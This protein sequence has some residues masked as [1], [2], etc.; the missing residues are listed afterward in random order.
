MSYQ[1][2]LAVVPSSPGYPLSSSPSI[3]SSAQEVH[4][5]LRPCPPPVSLIGV[6]FTGRPLFLSFPPY[7]IG[8][9]PLTPPGYFPELC[10]KARSPDLL[11]LPAFRP[12]PRTVPPPPEFL[13][14]Q[15]I[16]KAVGIRPFARR[17]LCLSFFFP[18]FSF[19]P[20]L[21]LTHFSFS[22]V[23][24]PS[25]RFSYPKNTLRPGPVIPRS[26][27]R[28]SSRRPLP[29]VPLLLDP[30]APPP[31]PTFFFLPGCLS[32]V[33]DHPVQRPFSSPSF[34]CSPG[35]FFLF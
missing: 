2:R 11:S 13:G 22:T 7:C 33:S 27:S 10:V 4:V 14:C 1:I 34:K 8:K 35:K 18:N 21:P 31:L 23:L 9:T 15:A 28:S 19:G 29:V 5:M 3:V 30:H 16:V 20:G 17:S 24:K 12:N 26:H 6:A 25:R 32:A